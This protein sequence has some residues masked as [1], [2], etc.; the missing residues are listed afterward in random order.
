M[1][2]L[3]IHGSPNAPLHAPRAA[4]RRMAATA[5]TADDG[6]IAAIISTVLVLVHL[7]QYCT[8]T[9]TSAYHHQAPAELRLDVES[10]DVEAC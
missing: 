5:T 1:A 10:A 7:Y 4:P 3:Q 2:A 9:S 6:R 8:S